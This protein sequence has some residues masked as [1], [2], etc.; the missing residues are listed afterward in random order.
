MNIRRVGS[1]TVVLAIL[2]VQLL[3]RLL[4]EAGRDLV[5][6]SRLGLLQELQELLLVLLVVGR[7]ETEP[8]NQSMMMMKW[9][10][11]MMNSEGLMF[12]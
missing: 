11:T 10:S 9:N 2:H 5:L 6:A 1:G 4:E 12:V 3:L 8:M 7:I